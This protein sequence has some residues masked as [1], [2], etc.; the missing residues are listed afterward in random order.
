[1][2]AEA[3]GEFRWQAG[4][5]ALALSRGDWVLIEDLD[6]APKDL[7]A[8]L[9]PIIEGRPLQVSVVSNNPSNWAGRDACAEPLAPHDSLKT[10]P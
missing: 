5:L 9:R 10:P 4:P 2:C 8:A 6:K 1:M 3:R 7:L